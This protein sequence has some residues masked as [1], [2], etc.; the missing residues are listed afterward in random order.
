LARNCKR[1]WRI[2]IGIT[3]VIAD[4]FDDF[5]LGYTVS[6]ILKQINGNWEFRLPCRPAKMDNFHLDYDS[7]DG[8]SD[9]E[10][11]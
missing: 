2:S 6:L 5:E 4:D 11:A 3:D 7:M 1:L 8:Y 10:D 9:E